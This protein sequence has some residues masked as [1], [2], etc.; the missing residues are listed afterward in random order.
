MSQSHATQSSYITQE[1][2]TAYIPEK[3]ATFFSYHDHL[4]NDHHLKM[5]V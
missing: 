3:H 5:V 4:I 1:E 2:H